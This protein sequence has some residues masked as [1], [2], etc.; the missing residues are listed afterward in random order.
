MLEGKVDGVINAL[1]R[2]PREPFEARPGEP[3]GDVFHW[4]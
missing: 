2:H 3:F 4:K 1:L